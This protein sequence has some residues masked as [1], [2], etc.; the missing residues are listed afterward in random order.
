MPIR[1]KPEQILNNPTFDE[2][3]CVPNDQ[4]VIFHGK[5]T[6]LVKIVAAGMTTLP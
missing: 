4:K 1:T 5:C 6:P 2:M 3:N